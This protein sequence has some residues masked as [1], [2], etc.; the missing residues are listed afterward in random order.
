M[1]NRKAFPDNPQGDGGELEKE[2]EAVEHEVPRKILKVSKGASPKTFQKVKSMMK[3][4]GYSSDYYLLEP[5]RTVPLH[6][7]N[8]LHSSDQDT[9]H[10]IVVEDHHKIGDK[11]FPKSGDESLEAEEVVEGNEDKNMESITANVENQE[12]VSPKVRENP[13]QENQSALDQDGGALNPFDKNVV[14][15]NEHWIIRLSPKSF[16]RQKHF[17]F[18]ETLFVLTI[19]AKTKNPPEE[20][21]FSCLEAITAS[22]EKA[23]DIVYSHYKSSRYFY[24]SFEMPALEKG[25]IN[26][27]KY[28]MRKESAGEVTEDFL[29][30]ISNLVTSQT[31]LNFEVCTYIIGIKE[32]NQL[33]IHIFRILLSSNSKL[34]ILTILKM[35]LLKGVTMK[36]TIMKNRFHLST[37]NLSSSEYSMDLMNKKMDL[38]AF[39]WS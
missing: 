7:Q 14:F 28:D 39:A 38:V 17:K 11:T 37:I 21:L 30:A 16:S 15:E 3:K 6:D 1:E 26:S 34:W 36:P 8:I 23:L 5:D 22:I 12:T 25:G 13:V 4:F 24:W 29:D 18:Q 20:S 2:E 33:T 32:R 31:D 19:R 35:R 27:R 9:K 10:V